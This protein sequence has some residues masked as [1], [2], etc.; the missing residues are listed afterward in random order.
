MNS[1]S[2]WLVVL[3][4]TAIMVDYRATVTK[5]REMDAGA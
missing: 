1:L 3:G 4:D 2:K 5:F